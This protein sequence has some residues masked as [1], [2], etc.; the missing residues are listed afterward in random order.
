MNSIERM[1]HF[2]Q[3]FSGDTKTTYKMMRAWHKEHQPKDGVFCTS[4]ATVKCSPDLERAMREVARDY[5]VSK[6][7][8]S[9]KIPLAMA[10]QFSLHLYG[11]WRNSLGIYT[12]DEDIAADLVKSPIPADTPSHIFARLPDW[13]VYI[14]MPTSEKN[15]VFGNDGDI[16]FLGFWAMLDA[17]PVINSIDILAL[18]IIPNIF[19]PKEPSRFNYT[20]IQMAISESMTVMEAINEIDSI[21]KNA[22]DALQEGVATREEAERK[23]LLLQLLPTLLWLCAEEPDISNIK[24]EP[25]SGS[26][27]R[28]PK[29]GVNKKT[30]DFVPPSQPTIF[31]LGKR[32][33][34]EIRTFQDKINN[35]DK[36]SATRKRPHIR[37]GHWHGVWKGTAQNKHFSVYWQPAVFVNAN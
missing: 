25:I 12:V 26:E 11:T 32:L 31:H 1:N 8:T 23:E 21:D 6:S 5:M 2:H 28:A 29:Y 4:E 37:R 10:L 18:S 30:G 17:K 24:G 9:E 33:G 20:P 35:K 16:Q 22:I 14:E 15:N 3:N 7:L 27:L 19:Y 34:G 36:S 13:C